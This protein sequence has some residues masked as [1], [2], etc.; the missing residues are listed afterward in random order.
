MR[1]DRFSLGG[2][3]FEFEQAIEYDAQG[4]GLQGDEFIVSGVN[5]LVRCPFGR[6]GA[7]VRSW[8]G[9]RRDIASCDR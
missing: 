8:V 6:T 7:T 9:S 2:A 1:I 4:R 5:R 3:G